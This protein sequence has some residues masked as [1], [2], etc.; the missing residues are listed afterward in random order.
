MRGDDWREIVEQNFPE[1]YGDELAK[2]KES[3]LEYTWHVYS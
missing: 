1:L 3:R 2:T